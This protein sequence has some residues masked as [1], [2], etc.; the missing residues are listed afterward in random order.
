MK[1]RKLKHKKQNF[2]HRPI[3]GQACLHRGNRG[4]PWWKKGF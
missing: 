3:P 2:Y 1:I 4:Q